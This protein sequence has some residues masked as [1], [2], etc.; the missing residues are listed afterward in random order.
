MTLFQKNFDEEQFE[1]VK[2]VF[3]ITCCYNAGYVL[4]SQLEQSVSTCSKIVCIAPIGLVDELRQHG[5]NNLIDLAEEKS[6][7]MDISEFANIKIDKDVKAIVLG[8][9]KKYDFR[10][11]AILSAYLQNK[12]QFFVTNEDRIYSAGTN[13]GICG[14][15]RFIPDIGSILKS[16]ETCQDDQKAVRVGKPECCAFNSIIRDHFKD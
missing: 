10:K 9:H 8:I 1:K 4:A 14:S 5:Y 6:S 2:R 11:M 16:V 12:T 13:S 3:D 15:T 7:K